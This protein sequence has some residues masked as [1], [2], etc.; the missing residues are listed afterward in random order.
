MKTI[1]E[2]FEQVKPEWKFAAYQKHYT[3]SKQDNKWIESYHWWL[4]K[5]KPHLI[6]EVIGFSRMVFNARWCG[7]FGII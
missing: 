2:V 5:E 6:E 7:C 1:Q 3:F 4:F